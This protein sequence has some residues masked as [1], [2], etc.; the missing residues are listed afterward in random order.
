MSIIYKSN[1]IREQPIYLG[2]NKLQA[3]YVGKK[4]VYPVGL[5]N[6]L[7][8]D[9]YG[10][11]LFGYDDNNNMW[12]WDTGLASFKVS[13]FGAVLVFNDDATIKAYGYS[14]DRAED[15]RATYRNKYC[16][17]RHMGIKGR[18][19]TELYYVPYLK[20]KDGDSVLYGNIE[21]AIP[22]D[23]VSE[24]TDMS[25]V[26]GQRKLNVY[27]LPLTTQKYFDYYEYFVD[28]TGVLINM[29]DINGTLM[30]LYCYDGTNYEYSTVDKLKS[31]ILGALP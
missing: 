7:S 24:H 3:I 17:R 22:W 26:N 16:V 4:K 21:E 18:H 1:E 28:E 19:L 2:K 10:D 25:I 13:F 31:H 14:C 8:W 5:E 11:G 23:S 29:T 20:S 27:S 6:A 9:V 12:E 30:S 15:E